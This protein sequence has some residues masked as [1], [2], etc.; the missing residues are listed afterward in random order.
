[1]LLIVFQI[2]LLRD[3]NIHLGTKIGTGIAVLFVL[4]LSVQ[5]APRYEQTT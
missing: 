2:L 1:M 3:R 4:V 5:M